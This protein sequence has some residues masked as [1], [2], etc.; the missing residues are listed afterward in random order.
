MDVLVF[1]QYG[2]AVFVQFNR[3]AVCSLDCD[4]FDVVGLHIASFQIANIR[5]SQ[6]RKAAEQENITHTFQVLLILGYLVVFQ[7]VQFIPSQ[8]DYFF[9]GGFQFRFERIVCNVL[10]MSFLETSAQ[11][12]F[13][14]SHLLADGAVSHILGITQEVDVFVQSKLVEIVKRCILLE[15]FEVVPHCC[16]FLI[17]GCRPVVLVAALFYKLI[18]HLPKADRGF[19]RL[20]FAGVFHSHVESFL[21]LLGRWHDFLHFKFLEN[22]L[23]FGIVFQQVR[24][25]F[26]CTLL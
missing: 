18:E 15:L 19:F 11:E 17:G 24:I 21:Q 20:F 13:E 25:D 1:V 8:E 26:G 7:L 23:D 4:Y 16:K 14:E 2:F 6:T 12:P 9:R 10:M 5:I 3:Q 22:I